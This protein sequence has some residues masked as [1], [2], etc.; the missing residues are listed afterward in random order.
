MYTISKQHLSHQGAEY[1]QYVLEDTEADT[2][3]T[4]TPLQGWNDYRHDLERA[5]I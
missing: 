4:I 1:D 3:V 2:T 5:R